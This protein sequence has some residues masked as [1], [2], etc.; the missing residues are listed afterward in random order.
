ML[1]IQGWIFEL[2]SAATSDANVDVTADTTADATTDTNAD[3]TAT[4]AN[5]TWI[6][7]EKW[8]RLAGALEAYWQR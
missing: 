8:Q 3:A 5:I 7:K 2:M 4:A 1:T 6:F